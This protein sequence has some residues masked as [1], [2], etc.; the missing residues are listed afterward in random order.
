MI[1]ERQEKWVKHLS[2]IDA[3]LTCRQG[4][5]GFGLF[6]WFLLMLIISKNKERLKE[7][8]TKRQIAV[9]RSP[10][11]MQDL[12]E[13]KEICMYAHIQTHTHT[14]HMVPIKALKSTDKTC[15]KQPYMHTPSGHKTWK[16]P[17][18]V[19]SASGQSA[20]QEAT[21]R[22]GHFKKFSSL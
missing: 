14:Y 7:H 20:S 11:R 5:L 3:Q 6:H 8:F 2:C 9:T 10:W 16:S 12:P 22:E 21:H 15:Y 13:H 1:M 18:E 19:W 4:M 17:S